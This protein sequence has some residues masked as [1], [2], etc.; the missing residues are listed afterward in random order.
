MVMMLSSGAQTSPPWGVPEYN[1]I[2]KP[3]G[4]IDTPRGHIDT[5]RGHVDTPRGHSLHIASVPQSF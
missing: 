4:H 2:D 1:D 5:P 3:R